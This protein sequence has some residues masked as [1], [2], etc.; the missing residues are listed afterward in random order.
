MFRFASSNLTLFVQNSPQ[1][2]QQPFLNVLSLLKNEKNE[3]QICESLFYRNLTKS[4]EGLIRYVEN[5]I[6]GLMQSALYYELVWMKVGT[7]WQF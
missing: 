5:Y 6:Y 3:M 2:C 7:G 1:N 4:I